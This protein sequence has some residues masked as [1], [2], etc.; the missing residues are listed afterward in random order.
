M[1]N[2]FYGSAIS[3]HYEK[4]IKDFVARDWVAV[5][6]FIAIVIGVIA[7]AVSRHWGF[8]IICFGLFA[9]FMDVAVRVIFNSRSKVT[10]IFV[11]LGILA[12]IAGAIIEADLW[13]IFP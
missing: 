10:S 6:I 4:K 8:M 12:I 11:V 2:H 3:E 7:S 5:G 1:G 13:N 9:S